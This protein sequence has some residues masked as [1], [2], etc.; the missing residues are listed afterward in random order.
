MGAWFAD[1]LFFIFGRPAFLFPVMIGLVTWTLFRSGRQAEQPSRANTA[2]RIAGF[3]AAAGGQLRP[4]DPALVGCRAC[5]TPP[6]AP[7]AIRWARA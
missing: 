4:G 7:S 6:A 2:V 5:R 1:L 3:R